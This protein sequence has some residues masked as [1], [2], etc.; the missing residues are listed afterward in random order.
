M[1]QVL[2]RHSLLQHAA[3]SGWFNQ[4]APEPFVYLLQVLL[5]AALLLLIICRASQAPGI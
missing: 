1:R 2:L 5:H 3:S 4:V